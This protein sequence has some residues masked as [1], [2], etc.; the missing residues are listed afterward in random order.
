MAMPGAGE[1]TRRIKIRAV[2]DNPVMGGGVAQ[3]YTDLATVWAKHEPVGSAIFF[4]TQQV[5]AAVTDRFTV[6][7]SS[8]ITDKTVTA[9]H[10]IEFSG[11]RYRIRRVSDW[12]GAHKFVLIETEQLGNA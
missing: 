8:E 1:L 4:G 9:N 3:Q 10:V 11:S 7:F 5:D 6:R 2:K 12:Q